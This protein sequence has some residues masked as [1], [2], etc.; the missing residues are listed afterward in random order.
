[1]KTK[2]FNKKLALN[3]NTIAN[4][5]NQEM[6]SV[7]GGEFTDDT[8][9]SCYPQTFCMGCPTLICE[10]SKIRPCD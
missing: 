2:K 1:M 5:G 10:E 4:L 3:K 7:K 6:I 9:G 8:C